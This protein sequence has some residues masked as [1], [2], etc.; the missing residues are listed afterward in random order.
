[1][2]PILNINGFIG[3]AYILGGLYITVI[4]RPADGLLAAI[5]VDDGMEIKEYTYAEPERQVGQQNSVRPIPR[6]VES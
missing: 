3:V 1:M 4:Q 5:V 2:N 6:I